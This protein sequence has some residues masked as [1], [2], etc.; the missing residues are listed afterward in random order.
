M[1]PAYRCEDL[2]IPHF[3]PL[4]VIALDAAGVHLV[5]SDR[6]GVSKLWDLKTV[7]EMKVGPSQF[8]RFDLTDPAQAGGAGTRVDF[9][10]KD[11]K[12][13]AA[14]LVGKKFMKWSRPVKH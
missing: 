9:K 5:S 14:L 10:D 8:A 1:V 11:G 4:A 13:L 3:S 6:Q 12:P 7:Q 2:Q